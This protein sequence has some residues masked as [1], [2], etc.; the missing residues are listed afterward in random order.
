MVFMPNEQL[1]RDYR[2][3]DSE[4]TVF[5]QHI[6]DSMTRDIT[7]F[8]AYG[9]L[10][11]N[12]TSLQALCDAFEVFPTDEYINQEYLSAVETRDVIVEELQVIIRAMALRVELKWGKKSPKYKS[13]KISELSQISVDTYLTRAR[14][15]HAFMT[16]NLLLLAPEGLTEDMLD[17]MEA[18]IEELDDAIRETIDKSSYRMEKTTER[19][20]KGN[21]L[22][23]LVS[24]YCE[25]GKRIWDKVNP[26]FYNDY[27][28]YD[29]STPGPL[30]APANLQYDQITGRI[31]WQSVP[32]ATSY[33]VEISYEG[34]DFEEIY[35]DVETETYYIPPSSPSSF[36]IETRARNA[37][38]L[39]PVSPL[40][41]NYDPPL[42]PPGYM[43]LTI[44]SASLHTIAIN[45]GDSMG[46]SAYRLYTSSVALGAP[47]GEFTL[48][49]EYTGTSYSG[50]VN[51]AT[52]NYFYV[53]AVKGSE[54]SA[55]SDVSYVDML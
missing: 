7:S 14:M 4:L 17:D 33:K 13:L 24:R 37:G 47:Q 16:E 51:A 6:C 3:T 40:T 43:S 29:S 27:V 2:M 25:I 28:I 38:G 12:V 8:T 46:A 11:A 54:I 41:V 39:G 9:V 18:K 30:T 48:V 45:W 5:T 32:N 55:P 42:Q 20:T 49:G 15:I 22:Y 31:S 21:E 53:V 35:A 1:M 23:D 26:A 19:I 52:R 34:G 50:S 44:T 10:E 36:I